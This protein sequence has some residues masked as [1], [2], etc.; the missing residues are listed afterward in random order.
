MKKMIFLLLLVS[1][2]AGCNIT[3]LG[4]GERGSGNRVTQK[5]DVPGFLTI[6]VSGAYE[7]EIVCQKERSLEIT[8]DDNILPL[9]TTEVKGNA[10]HIGSSKSYNINRAITIKIGVPDLE[11]ISSSGANKVS[12]SAIKNAEMEVDSSGASKLTLAGETK[13][14]K[15]DTSGASNIEAKEL[16]AEKV[17]VDSSGAGYV[18]V[19]ATAQLD[20]SASGASRIDYY[21]NPA[22]VNPEVSGG[23]SVN[24]K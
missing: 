15:I 24:K 22:T 7:V 14:L 1:F 16:F 8:G 9:V 23:S 12:I 2:G 18:S 13:K 3:G 4:K 20:A 21:G 5:R 17:D 10:L 11:A 19:Y 6:E